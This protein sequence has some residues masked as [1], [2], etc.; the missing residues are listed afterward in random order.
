MAAVSSVTAV[1]PTATTKTSLVVYGA[2]ISAGQAL[3]LDSADNKYKLADANV[4]LAI[5]AV[6]AVAITPGVDGSYGLVAT[7]GT[8]VL[9]G[10]SGGV[11]GDSYVVSATAGGIT[12]HGDLTAGQYV[13]RIGTLSSATEM[14]L[15]IEAT[16]ILHA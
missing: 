5:A 6:K 16:G 1:R 8:I 12:Q 4:S 7:S 9:V 2:T 10:A 13:S 3:Y 14:L 11:V 15:A